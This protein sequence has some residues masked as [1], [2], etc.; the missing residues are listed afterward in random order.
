MKHLITG[1]AGFIGCNLA[2]TL[3]TRGE[4]VTVVD[5]L[6]RPLT[7]LN[8]EWLQSQHGQR[9][10]FVKADIRDA[11][12]MRRAVAGHDV[13]YHLA[14]QV[15]VTTSVVDPRGDFE[16]N[17]LGTLNVLEAA[18][19]AEKP[20]VVFFASTNK[21]YGGMETVAI[22][23]HPTRY[24]YRDL[25]EGVPET[26]LLD[27]HSP[28]GCSKGAADQY[29]RDY[30]RIYGLKTVVFRQ[31]CLA[32]DQPVL[33]PFGNKPIAALRA[34]D[35][36]H[37]GRGWTKVRRVWKT[38]VKPVRRL[39]TMNGLSITLTHDHRMVRPHGLLTNQ[40]FAYGDFLAVL[41][42]ARYAPAWEEVS[43]AV[44]DAEQFMAAVQAKTS[45]MRCLNE[46]AAIAERLL[47][48]R[49]DRL[50]AVAEIVGRLFG[51]G[52]LSIHQRQSRS[53]PSYY[54]QHYGSL[55]E[56]AQVAQWLDWLG[57]PASGVIESASE[58]ELPSGRVVSGTSHRIQQQ[59]I[60]VFTLFELLGV[61]VG[62][63]VRV[64]YELPAWVAGGHRM[65]KRAFLRG[66]FGAELGRVYADSY[67]A[68][69]LAQSK[70][71]EYLASGRRWVQQLRDLL[72]DFGIETSSFEARPTAYKRGTTVQMTVRLLGG[73]D[74]YP[75]LAAIGYGFSAERTR[76][77]NTLLRWTWTHT[78]PQ[79]FE[80]TSD[81]YRADGPLC[82]DSLAQ[83]EELGETEV[84]DLEVE[85]ETHLFVAGGM[86]VS[87]CI[88]G[89]RQFGV[90]DQGWAAH[91]VIAAT[92]GRPISIYGDGKQ[93]R[94]MLYIDD[95]VAAYLAAL[96]RIDKV[97]GQ[98]YNIGGG[99][100]NTLSIW[101]EFRPLLERLA[102]RPIDVRHGDWRPGDQP[103][104]ISDIR[105]AGAELGW[106][107]KVSVED[108][109][110]RLVSWVQENEHL[111]TK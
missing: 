22:A 43:D 34:G 102:R 27:F 84:Y 13:V 75:K 107:P 81:L 12:A 54:V 49:G 31:S 37:S 69:S 83:I 9:L 40:Q 78:S 41:P 24:L 21:V 108:G 1:G 52:N 39:T 64:D 6:S 36:V 18:R 59:T 87:N 44:L 66:F 55:D 91:F 62:D 98:I 46:A 80:E 7:P 28:Y 50:L 4:A 90:E 109:I 8:L 38:G 56:L 77:L 19:T 72:A 17:A 25:P 65:V 103:V 29:V 105:K 3:L 79:W 26:Q 30:S 93:V 111:F 89:P 96:E 67:I 53:N 51:D 100:R 47:P 10:R 32:A 82:W 68:P 76:H 35:I 99:A 5:N 88:Y 58:S 70:D 73:Y 74:L 86:Q 106:Q 23:E 48:L 101:A 60:P 11:E 2:N 94:D 61:P 42:E 95:L 97:S 57:L 85:D 33:T 16:A 71:V 45:D 63:K 14:G 20:P 92:L 110:G 104:Y 15:A